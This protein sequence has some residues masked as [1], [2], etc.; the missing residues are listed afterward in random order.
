VLCC[1]VMY[2]L[3]VCETE[4]EFCCSCMTYRSGAL[5]SFGWLDLNI[6]SHRLASAL[7]PH[8]RT[9]IDVT[10]NVCVCLF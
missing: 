6:Q 5:D 2:S 3:L 4:R 8:H 10:V 1:D 9:S 7:A